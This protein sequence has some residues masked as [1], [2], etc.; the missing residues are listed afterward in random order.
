MFKR[1]RTAWIARYFDLRLRQFSFDIVSHRWFERLSMFFVSLTILVPALS[2]Y[3]ANVTYNSFLDTVTS[4]VSLYF[5]GEVFL[6][7]LA[8]GFF[9]YLSSRWN[10]FDFFIT[11]IGLVQYLADNFSIVSSFIGFHPLL[12]R[13]FRLLRL[14]KLI[15]SYKGLQQLVKTLIF[16]IPSS[17]NVVVLL[18]VLFY[19]YAVLGMYVFFCFF[20][21]RNLL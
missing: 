2:Y 9:Q 16:S 14:L 1:A 13:C 7:I 6:K 10:I 18:F 11:L 20:K 15:K 4:V 19:F 8:F 5:V 21:F 3:Q 17:I 12:F